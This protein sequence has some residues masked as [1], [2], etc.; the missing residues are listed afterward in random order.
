MSG[1]EGNRRRRTTNNGEE[2]E[3]E[4]QN[5]RREEEGGG[6]RGRERQQP[7]PIGENDY[8]EI[9]RSIGMRNGGF[10]FNKYSF[11]FFIFP[12]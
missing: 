4:Q 8:M 1:T 9:L 3:N 2:E 7:P 11:S 12:F 10:N 5:E 6:E